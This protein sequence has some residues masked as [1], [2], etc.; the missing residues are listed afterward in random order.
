MGLEWIT[1]TGYTDEEFQDA[2]EGQ[3]YEA[4]LNPESITWNRGVNYEEEQTPNSSSPSQRYESTPS[5]TLNF[6][7][8][9]DCT[10]VVDSTRTNMDTELTALENICYTYNGSIHRP[11]YVRV[12]WGENFVFKGVLTSF[13]TTYSLFKPDGSPLRVK[14]SLG[15]SLYVSPTTVEK[16]DAQ[17]SPDITH[18]V[19]VEQGMTLPQLCKKVW[20]D[21][22]HYIQV[23][24]YNQLNKFRNMAGIETLIFPP[25]IKSA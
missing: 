15:F 7:I 16:M 24:R 14:I 21:D 4:M 6:D 12:Q 19:T 22:S 25:I 5:D 3:P 8:V 18:Y 17:E 13:N 20:N 1:I 9:I 11:N 2:V 10:G 23:A